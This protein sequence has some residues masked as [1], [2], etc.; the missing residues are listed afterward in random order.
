MKDTFP[1]RLWTLLVLCV[2]EITIRALRPFAWN[3]FSSSATT[4]PLI[5]LL[6]VEVGVLVAIVDHALSS[7]LNW[8]LD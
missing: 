8:F 1:T 6:V 2:I 3:S 5:L 7:S 4:M